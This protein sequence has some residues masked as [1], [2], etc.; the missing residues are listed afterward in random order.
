MDLLDEFW[1]FVKQAKSDNAIT[2]DEYKAM[3]LTVNRLAGTING[4]RD[5]D[6]SA[7]INQVVTN[8][9]DSKKFAILSILDSKLLAPM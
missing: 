5:D 4:C 7:R 2:E 3:P 1:R 9:K 6:N 8:S